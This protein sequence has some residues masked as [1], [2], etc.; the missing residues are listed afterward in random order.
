MSGDANWTREALIPIWLLL[1]ASFVA[2]HD[3][4]PVLLYDL[5][6]KLSSGEFCPA[7]FFPAGFAWSAIDIADLTTGAIT[8]ISADRCGDHGIW[9]EMQLPNAVAW[10]N[11]RKCFAV[12]SG[13]DF[14]LL[15]ADRQRI[16]A[17]FNI[18]LSEADA[19][20]HNFVAE[21]VDQ[22]ESR[23]P[24]GWDDVWLRN[25]AWLHAIR[26]EDHE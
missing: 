26:R 18:S 10:D 15:A 5:D 2:K 13:S 16:Q 19:A 23:A 17:S 4:V 12:F 11:Y 3:L 1:K 7:E 20:I 8:S 9:D 14:A 24:H 22:L 21:T 6:D 25:S